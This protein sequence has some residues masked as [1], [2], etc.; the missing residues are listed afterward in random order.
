MITTTP[1]SDVRSTIRPLMKVRNTNNQHLQWMGKGRIGELTF[2]A[3]KEIVVDAILFM[4]LKKANS[5]YGNC[6]LV[7][8]DDELKKLAHQYKSNCY[9]EF[10]SLGI[11]EVKASIIS[12][13]LSKGDKHEFALEWLSSKDEASNEA[14]KLANIKSSRWTKYGAII[15]A[16]GVIAGILRPWDWW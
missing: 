14:I 5:R 8:D 4:N 7:W 11:P 1:N 9:A 2:P 16:I 10:E 15:T 13:D 12:G 6:G 3:N